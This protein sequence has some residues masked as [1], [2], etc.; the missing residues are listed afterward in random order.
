MLSADVTNK[1]AEIEWIVDSGATSHVCHDRSLFTELQ[2]LEKPLDIILGDGRTLNAT[3]CGSVIVMLESDS[4]KRKCK[5][6]DVLYVPELTYN[7]LSVSKAVDK[8]ISFT[9]N[10]SECVI[11]DS[12]QKLITI[13]TKA[14]S[15]YRVAGTMPKEQ[16][17]SV[18]KLPR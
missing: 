4:L 18:T 10:E 15:L 7:L 1:Q 3:G 2:N 11:K 16:V 6:Y 9:F 8:G 5:F 13:A 17:H 12:N 14:G